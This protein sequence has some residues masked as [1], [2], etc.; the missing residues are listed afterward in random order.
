MLEAAG[1]QVDHRTDWARLLDQHPRARQVIQ[2]RNGRR[3]TFR[4]R[5]VR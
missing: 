3:V 1:Y 2:Y 5:R 4:A